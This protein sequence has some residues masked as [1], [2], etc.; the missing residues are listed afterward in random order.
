[1]VCDNGISILAADALA[2]NIAGPSAMML[3]TKQHKHILVISMRWYHKDVNP[4][5]MHWSYVFLALTH[6]YT[7][8]KYND[9]YCFR[10]E[11]LWKIQIHFMFTYKFSLMNKDEQP[12]GAHFHGLV[13]ER[14]NSSALSLE[15][16]LS[17]TNP[18]MWE[19]LTHLPDIF[20]LSP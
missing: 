6:W 17:C 13:Q 7:V 15:L 16:R 10:E 12:C 20:L 1:M 5:L 8:M 2:S 3:L 19:S 11:K 4:L 18:S 9:L 14:H